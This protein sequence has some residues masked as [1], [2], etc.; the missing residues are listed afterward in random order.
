MITLLAQMFIWLNQMAWNN[1]IITR[2]SY[3]LRRCHHFPIISL[4]IILTFLSSNLYACR[5]CHET[6]LATISSLQT[7]KPFKRSLIL[8]LLFNSLTLT[9]DYIITRDTFSR[10]TLFRRNR[11]DA[12]P[13][14]LIYHAPIS[15]CKPLLAAILLLPL[16]TLILV[17]APLSDLHMAQTLTFFYEK[18]D[19]I[20]AVSL[21]IGPH[22]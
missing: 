12:H 20:P 5:T 21:G 19:S 8:Y 6:C 2:H 15:G 13:H 3:C 1:L 7:T 22:L 4:L 14:L 11:A 17:T 9:Y 18:I 16:R 10:T